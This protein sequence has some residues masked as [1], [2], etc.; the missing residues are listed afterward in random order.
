MLPATLGGAVSV[1]CRG[2]PPSNSSIWP[3]RASS[4]YSETISVSTNVDAHALAG[5]VEVVDDAD[6]RQVDRRGGHLGEMVARIGDDDRARRGGRDLGHVEELRHGPGHLHPLPFG[7]RRR[8]AAAEDEDPFGGERIGVGVG[9][10]FLEEEALELGGRLEVADHDSLDRDGVA[11]GMGV[12][13]PLPW[14]SWMAR[15]RGGGLTVTATEQVAVCGDDVVVRPL[16]R[17]VV[18]CRRRGAGDAQGS[19]RGAAR[20]QPRA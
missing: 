11:G 6:D 12:T 17:H 3:K 20:F 16:D 19:A 10:F 15:A 13:A 7:H 2:R 18:V 4:K 9:V 14:T 5:L 8:A 1:N